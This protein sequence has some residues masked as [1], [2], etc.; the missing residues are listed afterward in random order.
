M[1]SVENQSLCRTSNSI[2][3]QDFEC[4]QINE[5]EEEVLAFHT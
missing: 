2:W 1:K 3:T 5:E 4:G